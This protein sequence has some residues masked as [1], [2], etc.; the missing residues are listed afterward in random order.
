MEASHPN[1]CGCEENLMSGQL[2]A[3]PPAGSHLAPARLHY[4]DWLRVIA[5]LGVFLFH[6][7]NVFNDFDFHI[8][9]AERS[10][11][12]SIVQGF[13]FPWGMPLFFLIA[14]TGSWFALRR[15]SAGQYARERFDRLLI[16][17]L[18]GSLLLTPV[19]LYFE[20]RHKVETS[21]VQG[22]FAEFLGTLPWEANPR[23]FGV[24]GYHLW[25]LGFL[26]CFALLT[27]PLFRWLQGRTGCRLV[28]SLGK[29]C[30]RRGAILLFILPLAA[31]RLG[32]HAFFPEEH[33]WSDFFFLLAFFTLG[34]VLIAD[35]R[36]AE[37]VGRDW[38]ISLTVG[39]AAVVG[40]M[41]LAVTSGAFDIEAA[42]RAPGDFAF[43]FLIT[44]CA[45]CWTIFILAVAMRY[46]N[47]SHSFVQYGQEAIV[48]FF[49]LHQPAIIVIAYF[50]VQWD[51]N[52][53]LKAAVVITGSF[54]VSIALYELLIKRVQPL[55]AA[56]G[57]KGSRSPQP[58]ARTHWAAR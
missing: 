55:R 15:R 45:W 28:A 37:A 19:Q 29:L 39:I 51:A 2:A 38:W 48:P 47:F 9:N 11:A 34:Y 31:V 33:N 22:S 35:E 57:M 21:V 7:S 44:V 58:Q 54:A 41:A 5:I 12:I 43:W 46:L 18:V 14:G 27:L 1:I 16:P 49:V 26:F 32:L 4:L 50:A 36:L 25:F 6:A 3:Q 24:V 8:K 10:T 20:W 53:W 52:I 30:E 56:F 40:A 23:I 13:L 17:F 42:P